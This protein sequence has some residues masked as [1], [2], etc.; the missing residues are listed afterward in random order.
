M[1]F[2]TQNTYS[3]NILREREPEP[4]PEPGGLFISPHTDS[5]NR[6]VLL[7][8]G[9]PGKNT[10]MHPS[11]RLNISAT[12]FSPCLFPFSTPFPPL[13]PLS[14]PRASRTISRINRS[15]SI[16]LYSARRDCN[17]QSALQKKA[18]ATK[19]WLDQSHDPRI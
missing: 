3:G 6:I 15:K 4:D 11:A 10:R 9:T 7:I 13:P 8:S 19:V 2:Y 17:I 1:T 16:N 12:S 18:A 5:N 14:S